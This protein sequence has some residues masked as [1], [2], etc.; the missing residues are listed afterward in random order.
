METAVPFEYFMICAVL[1]ACTSF[2][3]RASFI[4]LSGKVD[5]GERVRRALQFLPAAAFPA[6]FAPAIVYTRGTENPEVNLPQIVAGVIAFAIAAKTQNV[7][8]TLLG[9]MC[10]LWVLRYLMG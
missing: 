9:G 3:S 2:F 7:Y 10:S 8:Y 4:L 5:L 1:M 6:I